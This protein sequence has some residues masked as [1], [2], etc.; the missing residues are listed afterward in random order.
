MGD[1]GT[2]ASSDRPGW[3]N[4]CGSRQR[5]SEGR[6]GSRRL[7]VLDASSAVELLGG[8]PAAVGVATIIESE[9]GTVP[10]HFDAEVYAA[11]R[12][13]FRQ[14]LVDRDRLEFVAQRLPSLPVERVSLT[15]LL[16]EAHLLADRLSSSDA[17][18]VALARLHD[19]ELV[20]SDGRLARDAFDLAHIRLITA[21]ETSL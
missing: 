19:C 15:S 10:A 20:T 11:F 21:P 12:R 7:I 8:S 18:Y 3:E 5:S 13:R 6:T 14:G 17:F 1:R 4:G 2:Q 16:W 9:R